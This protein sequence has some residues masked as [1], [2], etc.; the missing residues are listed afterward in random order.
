M[1]GKH[2]KYCWELYSSRA[3]YEKAEA[4]LDEALDK[5]LEEFDA[6]MK[7]TDILEILKSLK[8][9]YIHP[10]QKKYA[11]YGTYDTEPDVTAAHQLAR[12]AARYGIEI[13]YWDL[14]G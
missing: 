13:D 10:V 3:G 7:Q 11:E 12:A 9:K 2:S 8:A 14:R 6:Y 4:E 1:Q 5:A